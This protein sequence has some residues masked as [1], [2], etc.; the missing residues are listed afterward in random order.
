MELQWISASQHKRLL[1]CEW[2]FL[3]SLLCSRERCNLIGDCLTGCLTFMGPLSHCMSVVLSQTI[4]IP[5]GTVSFSSTR[6][7]ESL[8]YLA[9]ELA[10]HG[11]KL[12]R[13]QQVKIFC[14]DCFSLGTTKKDVLTPS[15]RY[16]GSH[17][18]GH[19]IPITSITSSQTTSM[20]FHRNTIQNFID[21]S[22]WGVIP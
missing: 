22:L 12:S 5:A 3:Y 1:V 18:P 16:T 17:C 6:V 11:K 10:N 19:L 20:L 8:L 15:L 14:L 7:F 21:Y 9:L 13:S 2:V 4:K